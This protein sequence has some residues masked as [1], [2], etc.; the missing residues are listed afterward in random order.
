MIKD[1]FLQILL[2]VV[3]SAIFIIIFYFI[4]GTDVE[5]AIVQNQ[6]TQIVNGYTN[7]YQ[8]FAGSQPYSGCPNITAPD[9]ASLAT[10]DAQIQSS[11]KA[12]LNE[13]Y[14]A[15]AVGGIAA[16]VLFLCVWFIGNRPTIPFR[17]MVGRSLLN[18]AAVALVEYTF[19]T[20]IVK[21]HVS[22]DVGTT[23]ELI[24]TS[25]KTHLDAQ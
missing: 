9:A 12:L 16:G 25:L 24:I 2:T 6:M 5:G 4:V 21:N 17:T 11:N 1:T 7:I 10:Q 18:V 19:L 3:L 23:N 20:Q 8:V 15:L 13:T 22:V 14:T